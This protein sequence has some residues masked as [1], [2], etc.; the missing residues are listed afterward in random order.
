MARQF[1]NAKLEQIYEITESIKTY[2]RRRKDSC[3]CPY[4]LASDN[5]LCGG[6]SARARPNVEKPLCYPE[7]L[8]Q[9]I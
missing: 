6:R 4:N 9:I 8:E 3:P 2:T 7:D 5:T 1:P